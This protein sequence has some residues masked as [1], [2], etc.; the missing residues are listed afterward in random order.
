[1]FLSIQSLTPFVIKRSSH[2]TPPVRSTERTF[3]AENTERKHTA[4][5]VKGCMCLSPRDRKRWSGASR[6]LYTTGNQNS[7]RHLVQ[8]HTCKTYPYKLFESNI[9]KKSLP[10]TLHVFNVLST[11]VPAF[12]KCQLP[13]CWS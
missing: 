7:C 4:D 6:C 9:I 13:A 1:M 12:F 2:S 3:S 11:D 10:G 8:S 5:K